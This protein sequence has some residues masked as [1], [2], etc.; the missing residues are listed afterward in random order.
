MFESSSSGALNV[1]NTQYEATI[2]LKLLILKNILRHLLIVR[3]I[4]FCYK[5][6]QKITFTM[7]ILGELCPDKAFFVSLNPS[8]QLEGN[9]LFASI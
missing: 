8:S 5:E 9:H 4:V 2:N 6:S 1:N 3:L 7:M